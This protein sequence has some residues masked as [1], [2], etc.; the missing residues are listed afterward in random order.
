MQWVVAGALFVLCAVLATRG[1]TLMAA[2][3]RGRPADTEAPTD[4][5]ADRRAIR[6]LVLTATATACGAVG[7]TVLSAGAGPGWGPLVAAL[8]R[9]ALFVVGPVAVVLSCERSGRRTEH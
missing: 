6:G 2:D 9:A 1:A 3:G 4:E 8:C 5:V 7:A